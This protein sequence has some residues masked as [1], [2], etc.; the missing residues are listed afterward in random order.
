MHSQLISLCTYHANITISSKD[1]SRR[2]CSELQNWGWSVCHPSGPHTFLGFIKISAHAK[3]CL[4]GL[5]WP[6]HAS[7]VKH[8]SMA[9]D[10]L[11][12]GLVGGKGATN[13]INISII[14]DISQ[15]KWWGAWNW[16]RMREQIVFDGV[17]APDLENGR[18]SIKHCSIINETWLMGLV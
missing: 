14:F 15:W 7:G 12:M 6:H 3:S 1:I 17:V 2:G 4:N 5:T 16:E 13:A 10:S 8:C 18:C 9:Y 11:F